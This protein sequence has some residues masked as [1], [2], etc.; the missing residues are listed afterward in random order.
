MVRQALRD[1]LAWDAFGAL[2]PLFMGGLA[3][4]LVGH[5][6]SVAWGWVGDGILMPPAVVMAVVVLRELSAQ[7]GLHNKTLATFGLMLTVTSAAVLFTIATLP[8]KTW[9]DDHVPST[10]LLAWIS[11]GLFSLVVVQGMAA[12]RTAPKEE[13]R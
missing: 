13:S 9:G 7:Q 3:L 5:S 4:V 11:L 10:T 8:K 12:A 2:F 1:R 6:L